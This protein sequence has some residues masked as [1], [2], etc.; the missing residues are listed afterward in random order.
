MIIG[1]FSNDDLLSTCITVSFEMLWGR[2]L[3]TNT[4][5]VI[6]MSN[7]RNKRLFV[8]KANETLVGASMTIVDVNDIFAT[9][10]F[11]QKCE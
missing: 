8:L 4:A 1:S 10:Y 2:Y 3:L 6:Q 11:S 5:F 7:H 9:R